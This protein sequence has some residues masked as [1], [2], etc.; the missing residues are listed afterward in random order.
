M[1]NELLGNGEHA[2]PYFLNR[3]AYLLE[4]MQRWA[5]AAIANHRRI[6]ARGTAPVRSAMIIPRRKSTKYG[7]DLT[8][9]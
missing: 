9:N 7:I 4:T 6:S 8:R 2:S 3:S 1:K 5:H